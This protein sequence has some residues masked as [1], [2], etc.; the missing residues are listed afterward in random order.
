ML[1]ALS[2]FLEFQQKVVVFLIVFLG[3]P[4]K[5]VVMDFIGILTIS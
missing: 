3:I 5:S 1:Y 4:T 2:F